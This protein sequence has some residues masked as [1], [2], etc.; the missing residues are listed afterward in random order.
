[1][2]HLVC[3]DPARE[4]TQAVSLRVFNDQD[5]IA[6]LG[7]PRIPGTDAMACWDL[8]NV[9]ACHAAGWHM[10]GTVRNAVHCAGLWRSQTELYV[11]AQVHTGNSDFVG[12]V[13]TSP[14]GGLNWTPS[15]TVA[16]NR[17]FDIV[18][19]GGALY[20]TGTADTEYS[21]LL[22][23]SV[24]G[25]TKWKRVGGTRPLMT[26][27]LAFWNGDLAGVDHRCSFDAPVAIAAWTRA[28]TLVIAD[29]GLD[30]VL[31]TAPSGSRTQ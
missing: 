4:S 14:D 2:R 24:D 20:A 29:Q 22:Y 9:H 3:Q 25:G 16:E 15:V 31:W 26:A 28:N 12:Q 17:A 1:M 13:F 27:R 7:V 6:V 19:H 10:R 11:S 8:G 23:R 5:H 21:G 18:A 30:A